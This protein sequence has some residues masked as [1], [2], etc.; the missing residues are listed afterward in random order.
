MGQP[1]PALGYYNPTAILEL[2]KFTTE[3]DRL[4]STLYATITPFKGLELKTQYGMDYLVLKQ[5][6]FQSPVTGD[7]YSTNGATGASNRKFRRWTWTNTA[8]YNTTLA[9]KFNLGLLAGIEEQRTNDSSW[10]GSKTNVSD[11]FFEDYQGH[12]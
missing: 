8:N 12:G 10:S 9:E 2:N 11:P 3:T 4:L 5:T 6:Y 1:F 7:G